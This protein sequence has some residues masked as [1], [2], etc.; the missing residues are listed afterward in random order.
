MASPF[1]DAIKAGVSGTPGTGSITIG[2]VTSGF[3][4]FSAVPSNTLVDYRAED[5]SAWEIGVGLWDGTTLTRTLRYS[6]TGSLL[7]LTSAA[8]VS[9]VTPAEEVQPH[10]GGGKWGMWTASPGGSAM[11]T[12]GL[13]TA[14]S[15]GSAAAATMSSSSFLGMQTRLKYTSATTADSLAGVNN[16][17]SAA[18]R[19]TTALRGGWEMVVR[20]GASQLPTGPRMFIGLSSGLGVTLEPS[21]NVQ[22]FALFAK[23]STDTNIQFV[24][25]DG[26]GTGTKTDTGIAWA[27]NDWFEAA[28]WCAPGGSEVFG[29]LVRLNNPTGG[30]WYGSRTTDL[31][32]SGTLMAPYVLGSLNG[33]NTGT[34]IILEIGSVYLRTSF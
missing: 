30:I 15:N 28:M 31:P 26:A 5:G 24:T 14:S 29:S 16:S 18:C 8:T 4:A 23:D 19:S 34:A 6:S 13:G 9:L 3:R 1:F 25:N 2:A 12:L 21:A 17:N 27:A 22:S 11:G 32:A 10:I 20:F 33:T 7:S